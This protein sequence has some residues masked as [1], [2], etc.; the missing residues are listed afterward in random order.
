[1]FTAESEVRKRSTMILYIML[2]TDGVYGNSNGNQSKEVVN[3][4]WKLVGRFENSS[5]YDVGT[6]FAGN[7]VGGVIRLKIVN[8]KSSIL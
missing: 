4:S 8:W 7:F 6:A 1:M 5:S 3:P 2:G